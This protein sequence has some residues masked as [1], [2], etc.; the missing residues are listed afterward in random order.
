MTDQQFPRS[1]RL[2]RARDFERVLKSPELR[3][4]AG[5]LRLQAVFNRMQGARL[6]LVVGKRAVPRA[7]A[8]NRIKRIV[9]DR[10]RCMRTQLPALDIVVRVAGPVALTGLHA[11]LDRLFAELA[12]KGRD[13]EPIRNTGMSQHGD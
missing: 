7:H 8:R 3:A 6:G 13:A 2:T 5:P 4:N 11:G 1:A 9:R 12:R 10:F